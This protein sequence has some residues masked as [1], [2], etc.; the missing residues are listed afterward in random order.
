MNRTKVVHIIT[1]L[2]LGGAQQNTLFTVAHLARSRYD[3]VL[4]SG[5][6]GL[7]VEDAKKLDDVKVYLLT[8]LVREIR[9]IKDLIALFKIRNILKEL[10]KDNVKI[11]SESNS[12]IIVHTHSVKAGVLGRW[13]A[14]M[15]GVKI[16]ISSIHGFSFNDYQPSLVRAFYIYL[17]KLTSIITTK[18]VAVSN[19]DIEKGIRNK[20]FTK[21]KVRLIRSGID[22]SR[23]MNKNH[24]RLRKRKELGIEVEIP[25]VAMIACFKPQKSPLDFVKVAKI[26]SDEI[27]DAC[28][29]IVGDGVIRSKIEN[30]IEK[31]SMEDKIILLGW[32]RDIPE[33]LSCID[34]L[35]LTSLW[36]G[37][38]RV[39]PQAMASG[40][41]VVATEVDGAPEAIKNGV[42]GFLLQP[43]DI[44]GMAERIISLIRNPDRA[45]EMGEEGR[46]SVGEFDIW[47]MVE[48][49]EELYTSLLNQ[50]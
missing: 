45:R 38:P 18:F 30:L 14:Y 20:I 16:I 13:A 9:P 17:E 24:N 37:L 46:K 15:A 11:E 26:I 27:P 36:E 12:Q 47:K 29:L 2:D 35:V 39:F 6:N 32:R 25:V 49:Q 44:K 21:D 10:K 40:I 19:A 3:P 8:E 34:I 42:T 43:R 33:I 48:Q 4:I 31:I 22:I 5:T 7:L 1:K 28:F 41:P 23:F 50:C